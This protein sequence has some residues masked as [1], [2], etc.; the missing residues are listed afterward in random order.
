[1]QLYPA[2]LKIQTPPP[3][4]FWG[5]KSQKCVRESHGGTIIKII[6]TI[7]IH[8]HTRQLL[9]AEDFQTNSVI[10]T[11]KHNK[12]YRLHVARQFWKHENN[13]RQGADSA[14]QQRA[15]MMLPLKTA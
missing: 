15:N 3:L 4:E 1:M 13:P 2:T 12:G 14:T 6:Q 7:Q 8:T 11:G 9:K 10:L 5:E